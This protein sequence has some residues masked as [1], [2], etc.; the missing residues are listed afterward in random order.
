MPLTV[1]THSGA[2]HADDVLAFGLIRSFLDP[3]AA[4]VRSRDA[5][6]L[7]QADVVFDVG[8]RF[9]PTTRRFDHHQQAY[10]GPLSSA[11]MVL[12]WLA[13]EGKV[14]ASLAAHLRREV[15]DYVDAVDNGRV[16]PAQGVPCFPS[17]VDA[18]VSLGDDG[19]SLD[20]AYLAAADFAT[21]WVRAIA[22]QHEAKERARDQV[23]AAMLRAE[24]SGSRLLELDRYLSWK[25]PYF[26]LGGASH[27]TEFALFQG[28]EGTWRVVA[29]PPKLGDF[30][31]KRPLPEAWAGLSDDA[32]TAVVG[33]PGAVFCHKNRFVAVFDTR[34]HAVEALRRWQLEG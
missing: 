10:E 27:P 13:A 25:E 7:E 11:G 14:S 28:T 5:A 23:R 34:E 4:L 24:A 33:V 29:I 1:A 30:G 21:A 26:D 32:L 3:D 12:D 9:D 2:F 17:I 22:A 20:R 18:F 6:R 19:P 16:T 31:Q 15:V 8:G